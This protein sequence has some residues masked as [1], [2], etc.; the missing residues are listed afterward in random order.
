MRE[1][2]GSRALR[3][4]VYLHNVSTCEVQT[5]TVRSLRKLFEGLGILSRRFYCLTEDGRTVRVTAYG[6]YR[7]LEAG[8]WESARCYNAELEV[9]VE[10]VEPRG[11]RARLTT[12]PRLGSS[13]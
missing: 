7:L 12:Q 1:S 11:R 5:F 2:R 10:P 3:Y 8:V 13:L 9:V 6:V 4:R